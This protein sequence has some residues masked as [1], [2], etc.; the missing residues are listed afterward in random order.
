MSF[1]QVGINIQ[2]RLSRLFG[3]GEGFFWRKV[4]PI[5][6]RVIGFRQ[7]SVGERELWIQS[8]RLLEMCEAVGKATFAKLVQ[9][10]QA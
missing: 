1:G 3:F 7:A 2:C 9:F 5:T 10:K 8:D 6:N 4:S